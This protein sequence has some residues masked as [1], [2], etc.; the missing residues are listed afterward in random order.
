YYKLKVLTEDQE[1]H[2]FF[3]YE[4]IVKP[5]LFRAITHS[6]YVDKRYLLAGKKVKKGFILHYWQELTGYQTYGNDIDTSLLRQGFTDADHDF[7]HN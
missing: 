5:A 2:A 7:L 6:H 3:V 1:K 4:N